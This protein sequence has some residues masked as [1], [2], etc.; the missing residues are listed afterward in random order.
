MT[1]SFS[2]LDFSTLLRAFTGSMGRMTPSDL[3]VWWIGS[4]SPVFIFNLGE[5]TE[6]RKAQWGFIPNGPASLFGKSPS[7]TLPC[8]WCQT[9]IY[10]N[11]IYIYI[12]WVCECHTSF[13]IDSP[14]KQWLNPGTKAMNCQSMN[15]VWRK[16]WRLLWRIENRKQHIGPWGRVIGHDFPRF[17]LGWTFVTTIILMWTTGYRG[18][19][20]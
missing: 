1:R 16:W 12:I 13:H 7:E 4:T 9:L 18:F 11:Y 14:S 19:D 5:L 20:P 15:P 8:P 10:T 3:H 6:S 2:I 17:F